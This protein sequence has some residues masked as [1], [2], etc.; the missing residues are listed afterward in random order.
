ME[1]NKYKQ[2]FWTLATAVALIAMLAIYTLCFTVQ[3]GTVGVVKTLGGIS[4]VETKPN[5]YFKAPWPIQ[6]VVPVDTRTRLLLIK[7][8]EE[9]TADEFNLI[10]E[11]TVGWDVS[12][13]ALFVTRL[14]NSEAKA[15]ELLRSRI[16]DARMRTTHSIRLGDIISTKPDQPKNFAS[17]EKQILDIVQASLPQDKEDKNNYGINVRYVRVKRLAFPANVTE[18]IFETMKKERKRLSDKYLVE[19]ENDAKIIVQNAERE[20]DQ[21]LA[22]AEAQAI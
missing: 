19:G 1:E 5:I 6:S 14:E 21:K 18:A 9:L 22:E 4:K 16:T 7:G 10:S 12:D 3:A 15:E 11:L 2:N 8:K 17:F 20:R 13:P